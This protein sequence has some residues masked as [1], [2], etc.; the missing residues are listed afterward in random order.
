MATAVPEPG[1][2]AADPSLVE[3]CW[4]VGEEHEGPAKKAGVV[5]SGCSSCF[6]AWMFFHGFPRLM[7]VR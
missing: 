6:G 3:L 4:E 2:R 7:L 5:R 1:L